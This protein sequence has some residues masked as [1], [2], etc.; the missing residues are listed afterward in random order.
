MRPVASS[1]SSTLT[2]TLSPARTW[3][4]SP[5]LMRASANALMWHSP[6]RPDP[7]SRVTNT[8]NDCT[9]RTVPMSVAP[10][11][12]I[13]PRDASPSFDPPSRPSLRSVSS[14]R[15]A[16]ASTDNT[17]PSTSA[18]FGNAFAGSDT[19]PSP[20]LHMRTRASAPRATATKHPA[21]VVCLT[22]PLIAW[23]GVSAVKKAEAEAWNVF[24]FPLFFASARWFLLVLRSISPCSPAPTTTASKNDPGLN[25]RHGSATNSSATSHGCTLPTRRA[26]TF[27][28]TPPAPPG[29][30]FVTHAATTE[31]TGG[32]SEALARGRAFIVACTLRRGASIRVTVTSTLDPTAWRSWRG[33]SRT[34]TSSPVSIAGMRVTSPGA[35]ATVSV[36]AETIATTPG[37]ASPTSAAPRIAAAATARLDPSVDA[38]RPAPACS[39]VAAASRASSGVRRVDTSSMFPRSPARPR[40][41][42]SIA[43]PA[44]IE[45]SGTRPAG[46]GAPARSPTSVAWSRPTRPSD[47]A[48]VACDGCTSRTVPDSFTPAATSVP[49]ACAFVPF[50]RSPSV[51]E[52][53]VLDARFGAQSIARPPGPGSAATTSGTRVSP[54]HAPSLGSLSRLAN[55]SALA[56]RLGSFSRRRATNATRPPWSGRETIAYSG[57][58]S[59]TIASTSDPGRRGGSS[60]ATRAREEDAFF[61]FFVRAPAAEAEASLSATSPFLAAMSATPS[62]R[63]TSKTTPFR[64]EPFFAPF[65]SW[66]AASKPTTSASTSGT[67]ASTPYSFVSPTTKFTSVPGLSFSAVSGVKN[68]SG[69][70]PSPSPSSAS[71]P[72]T[73]ASAASTSSNTARSRGASSS[74]SAAPPRFPPRIPVTLEG[75]TLRLIRAWP[76]AASVASTATTLAKTVC[77]SANASSGSTLGAPGSVNRLGGAKPVSRPPNRTNTPDAATAPATYPG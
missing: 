4:S 65:A 52:S 51:S 1:A 8:P 73:R 36:S 31:P 28:N 43:A 44:R 13:G 11:S 56:P 34:F 47:R 64:V 55:A 15:P 9:P 32:P 61:D 48:T 18:P 10:G 49:D 20:R 40:V 35:N 41:T 59:S 50:A 19:N 46:I 72:S 14:H 67:S 57:L 69:G 53:A 23:P 60:E 66:C 5:S 12:G 42:T 58:R 27:A 77:P 2:L 39:A 71:L 75:A 68:P 24:F 70:A 76:P 17:T 22:Y 54:S 38:R 16:P 7:P 37:S 26:S 74:G 3:L 33:R 6:L 45:S 63:L 25:R 21:L 30:T 62:A 29:T